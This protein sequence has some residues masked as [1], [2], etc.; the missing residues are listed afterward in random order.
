MIGL[1]ESGGLGAA[2]LDVFENEPQVPP[3][4][5]ALPQVVL[6]PHVG[7][8]T[9]DGHDAMQ[10]MVVANVAAYAAG[11]AVPTPVP[12]MPDQSRDAQPPGE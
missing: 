5:S 10:A 8:N 12:E 7:G 6:A 2:G 11:R 9:V 1:L 3:A 4:L